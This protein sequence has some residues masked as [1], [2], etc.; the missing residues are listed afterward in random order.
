MDHYPVL[1][2]NLFYW[3]K[4]FAFLFAFLQQQDSMTAKNRKAFASVDFDMELGGQFLFSDH[5][6]T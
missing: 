4:P 6:S 2:L 1:Y 5:D 3:T